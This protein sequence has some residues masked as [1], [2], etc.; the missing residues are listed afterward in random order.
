MWENRPLNHSFKKLKRFHG[1]RK[2]R[3]LIAKQK[4]KR[5]SFLEDRELARTKAAA[6]KINFVAGLFNRFFNDYLAKFN[7]KDFGAMQKK[8]GSGSI[9]P[10]NSPPPTKATL[11]MN[12]TKS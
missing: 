8:F 12:M 3:R 11:P 2:D 10:Q 7:I 5:Q 9:S 4:E 6:V 1:C